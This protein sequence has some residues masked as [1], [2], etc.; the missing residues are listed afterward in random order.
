MSATATAP[1]PTG[2]MTAEEFLAHH[3]RPNAV[4]RRGRPSGKWAITSRPG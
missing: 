2:L 4:L 3:A 1:S